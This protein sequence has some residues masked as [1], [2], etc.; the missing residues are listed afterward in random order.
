MNT[1][2]TLA[3]KVS[4]IALTLMLVFP[5]IEPAVLLA[6]SANDPITVTQSVTSGISISSPSDINL[7]A[8]STTQNS[9]VGSAAWTVTTNNQAGYTLTLNAST[10]P[11]L[12]QTSPAEQFTDYSEAVA[13]TPE[14]WSVSSAYEFGF[15]ARGSDV[16][17][18]TWG[19]DTDCIAG[20]DVPSA[21]LNWRGF[22]GTTTI[23]IA[24]ASS[25]TSVSGTAST[26]CV[27]TEQ[28]SVFAPSG[29]YTATI[30]ATATVQ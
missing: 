3:G 4:A 24:S 26:M 30:T 28:D 27:A 5:L 20:A 6:Q 16:P 2:Y 10:D 23:Q 19:T 12:Q 9:A 18:G 29:T 13:N 15:S 1:Y 7:T 8:L 11:A 14:T 22:N 17:T 25:E 21:T